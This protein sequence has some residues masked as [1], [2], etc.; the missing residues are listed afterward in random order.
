MDPDYLPGQSGG[1]SPADRERSLTPFLRSHGHADGA[2][3]VFNSRISPSP[4]RSLHR[5]HR[6]HRL[7]TLSDTDQEAMRTSTS[8]VPRRNLARELEQEVRIIH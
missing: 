4:S 6:R 1:D 8:T 5:R 7:S 3:L 2:G